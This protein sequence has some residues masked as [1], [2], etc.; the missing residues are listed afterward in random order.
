MNR[1]LLSSFF[2]FFMAL[3]SS[4]QDIVI[5]L[6]LYR[7]NLNGGNPLPAETKFSVS[8][9]IP[10]KIEMVKLTIYPSK[11]GPNSAS[12]YFWKSPF[13]FKENDFLLTVSN[14]LRS[15]ESYHLNF[16]YY[17]KAGAEQIYEIRELI[18]TNIKTYM[19]SIT[20]ISGSGIKFSESDEVILSNLTR[21]VEQGAYYFE[22][23][24]GV[25][26]PGFSDLTQIKL[27][28]RKTL[29][30]GKA[31]FNVIGL[32]KK[33]NTKAAFALKYLEEL[34]AILSAELNQYLSPN[35]LV[36]VDER[37][38]DNYS[39]EK[40]STTIPLNVG[41]GA[42]S[43]S[44]NLPQQEFVTSIYLGLSLPLGNRTF[45]PIMNN[46]SISTGFFINSQLENSLEE[47]ISGPIMDLPV[48]VGL[49]YNF[50]RFLRLNAGG[51][52]LTTES[53]AA[54]RVKSFEPFFGLSAEF[55]LW[56]GFGKKK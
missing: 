31:K 20:T 52:F 48:Y 21:I 47:Q 41:Y 1:I 3:Y 55:N 34:N 37:V 27:Q 14:P 50:F 8:G 49:G 56:L 35:M 54:G 23:P 11:K 30:T 28:Q 32:Q 44:K 5:N 22:L 29:K 19:S 26:F 42:I 25:Q 10:E 39:T 16:G 46:L 51:T 17:Q 12:N 53:V 24:D 40:T 33:D 13:G 15:N 7:G 43:L 4:A 6:D 38:F 9:G 18:F 2:C 36:R 45:S